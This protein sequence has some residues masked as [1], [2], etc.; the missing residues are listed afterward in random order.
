MLVNKRGMIVTGETYSEYGLF[1]DKPP[2]GFGKHTLWGVDTR[3]LPLFL[4]NNHPSLVLEFRPHMPGENDLQK[5][6]Y[7]LLPPDGL[8]ITRRG[9]ALDLET[10]PWGDAKPPYGLTEEVLQRKPELRTLQ[11]EEY[12]PHNLVVELGF[13]RQ[14]RWVDDGASP[15]GFDTHLAKKLT[16]GVIELNT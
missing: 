1:Y 9:D 16:D 15:W 5:P 12:M 7:S 8:L 13:A 11:N 6:D 4:V 2:K 10:P 3:P 14:L